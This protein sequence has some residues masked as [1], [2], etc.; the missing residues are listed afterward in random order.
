MDNHISVVAEAEVPGATVAVVAVELTE[1]LP[2]TN[3]KISVITDVE[4]LKN[5]LKKILE[6]TAERPRT[7]APSD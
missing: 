3:I 4:A 6:A 7:R 5:K 2:P 1:N